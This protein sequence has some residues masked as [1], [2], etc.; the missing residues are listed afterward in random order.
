[1]RYQQKDGKR[2]R[3]KEIERDRMTD[4]QKEIILL[5]F[6]HIIKKTYSFCN[7]SINKLFRFFYKMFS[8]GYSL[9]KVWGPTGGSRG[10]ESITPERKGLN[11]FIAEFKKEYLCTCTSITVEVEDICIYEADGPEDL[12][13][14]NCS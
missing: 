10:T 3:K 8:V 5:T 13:L 1:M 9:G 2:D 6:I 7:K 11:Y 4:K 14:K 12:T